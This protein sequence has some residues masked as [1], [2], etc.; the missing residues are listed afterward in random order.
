MNT[1]IVSDFQTNLKQET[2]TVLCALLTAQYRSCGPTK[3]ES[4]LKFI[5]ERI[6]ALGGQ[7][8]AM[9]VGNKKIEATKV[10]VHSAIAVV[11]HLDT[12]IDPWFAT[13][14][15]SAMSDAYKCATSDK[16]LG[17]TLVALAFAETSDAKEKVLLTSVVT[18]DQYITLLL[19]VIPLAYRRNPV[20]GLW[21]SE[22]KDP[23]GRPLQN[24]K[25][26]L[27]RLA[28]LSK[29]L[30]DEQRLA[31]NR[32]HDLANLAFTVRNES[33]LEVEQ[34]SNLDVD[35]AHVDLAEMVNNVYNEL[36]VGR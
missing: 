13:C 22:R 2:R 9:C 19:N 24:L 11:R 18:I 21:L 33:P 29:F 4:V 3:N 32:A 6:H 26:D 10:L 34:K 5:A 15:S 16:T 17:A 27:D 36:M 8:P 7:T 12:A 28:K 30:G 20:S 23:Q 35:D 14:I 1:Q 31:F 25:K